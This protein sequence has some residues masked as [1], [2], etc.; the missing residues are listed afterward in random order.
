MKSLA[1]YLL[2]NVFTKFMIPFSVYTLFA[3]SK[4]NREW[5]K[6]RFLVNIRSV[7]LPLFLLIQFQITRIYWESWIVWIVTKFE[8][9]HIFNR[10]SSR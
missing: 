1:R 8:V 4:T 3:L 6:E 7:P 2:K 5:D 10:L 9:F